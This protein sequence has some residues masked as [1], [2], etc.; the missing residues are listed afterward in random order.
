MLVFN[1]SA[2]RHG[3]G[4]APMFFDKDPASLAWCRVFVLFKSLSF[5]NLNVLD[6]SWR[7]VTLMLYLIKGIRA[8]R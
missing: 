4:N 6:L 7:C 2:V 1:C 8:D 5:R 3:L